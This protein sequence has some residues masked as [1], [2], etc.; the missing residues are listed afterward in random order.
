MICL[1]VVQTWAVVLAMALCGFLL[2][3]ALVAYFVT[4]EDPET[5]APKP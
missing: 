5:H 3:M 4:T 1:T 2:A